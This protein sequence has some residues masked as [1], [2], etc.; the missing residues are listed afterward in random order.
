MAP[1]VQVVFSNRDQQLEGLCVARDVGQSACSLFSES[2]EFD[3]Q[4]DELFRGFMSGSY[5]L[6][7]RDG[8][9]VDQVNS[10][11]VCGDGYRIGSMANDIADEPSE[12]NRQ[13]NV[14]PMTQEV[15][16]VAGFESSYCAM[17]LTR[18]L[19]GGCLFGDLHQRLMEFGRD[20][21]YRVGIV[22]SWPIG[23]WLAG[24]HPIAIASFIDRLNQRLME[25]GRSNATVSPAR[26]DFRSYV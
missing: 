6:H 4:R 10:A 1:V 17:V 26:R 15:G 14:M 16:E 3:S 18:L 23:L 22:S 5:E 21:V 2:F 25:V 9:G 19:A 13:L 7:V 8:G 12:T 11:V 20:V 24:V